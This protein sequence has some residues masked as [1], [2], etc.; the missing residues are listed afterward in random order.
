MA[1]Q[2][3]PELGL[4]VVFPWNW[5]GEYGNG[6]GGTLKQANFPL[7]W[8]FHSSSN[9]T[10]FAGLCRGWLIITFSYKLRKN[11]KDSWRSS[12]IRKLWNSKI[13]NNMRHSWSIYKASICIEAHSCHVFKPNSSMTLRYC[14]QLI[15]K[16]HLMNE[17]VL[18]K[19]TFNIIRFKWKYVAQMHSFLHGK[20]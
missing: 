6:Y 12:F 1:Y 8:R 11:L 16:V 13:Y 18:G 17:S 15:P 3:V 5:T 14:T 2:M 20:S 7:S 4:L 9:K 19:V 10:W